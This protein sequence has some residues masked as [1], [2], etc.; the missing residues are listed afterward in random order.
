MVIGSFL[1]SAVGFGIALFVAPLLVLLNPGFVPGPMLFASLFLAVIMAFRGWR[2]IDPKILGLAGAGLFVGTALGALGLMVIV[3]DKWP[4]FFAV[5]ILL[6][7]AL[8]AS[9][10]H[11]SVTRRNV[12]AASIISGVMGTI[13]GIHGPPMALLYQKQAGNIVRATL[14]VFFVMAYAIALFALWMIGLFGKKGPTYGFRVGT[15]G[16]CRLHP[17]EIFDIAARSRTLAPHRHSYRC[18]PQ[19]HRPI[20]QKVISLLLGQTDPHGLAMVAND[21]EDPKIKGFS[22]SGPVRDRPL[23][24][25]SSTGVFQHPVRR[26]SRRPPSGNFP[27]YRRPHRK[28]GREPH[29]PSPAALPSSPSGSSVE[30][31]SARLAPAGLR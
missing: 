4:Q 26:A 25:T 18:H 19:C 22:S 14:A 31:F 24:S 23:N 5:I 17:R 15:W 7:V 10:V 9:G 12:V 30:P 1:Q 13:A 8:S 21:R 2:V 27:S 11:I 29:R 16:G 6:A 28:P 20:F 3:A